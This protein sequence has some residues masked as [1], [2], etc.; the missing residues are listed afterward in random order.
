MQRESQAAW[1]RTVKVQEVIL[2]ALAR[3]ITWWQAAEILG[4]SDRSWG[5]GRGATRCTVTT[6]RAGPEG[7]RHPNDPRRFAPGA[8]SGGSDALGLGKDGCRRSCAGRGSRGWRKRTGF[9]GSVTSRRSTASLVSRQRRR[10]MRL[11]PC[12]ARTW[13]GSSR[14]RRS[15]WWPRTTPFGWPIGCGRSSGHRGEGRWGVAG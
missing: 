7:T 14:C 8:R 15:G 12:E 11:S 10:A 3:R 13:T 5:A 4:I 9:C 6:G 2:R 1:E